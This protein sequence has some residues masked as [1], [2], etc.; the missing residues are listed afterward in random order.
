MEQESLFDKIREFVGSICWRGLLWA[1]KKT[2]D[3]YWTEVYE[4]EK[5]IRDRQNVDCDF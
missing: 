3:E 5:A 4:Q 2:P 1:L